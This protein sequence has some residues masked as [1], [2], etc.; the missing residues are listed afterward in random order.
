MPVYFGYPTNL[1]NL[2]KIMNYTIKNPNKHLTEHNDTFEYVTNILKNKNVDLRLFN[3]DKGQIIL[4]YE[5]EEINDVWNNI[6]NVDEVVILLMQLKNKFECETQI[7]GI[8]LN[9]NVEIERME[10]YPITIKNFKPCV[11]CWH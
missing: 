6:M 7:I 4:G 8:N 10:N 9:Y 5:I 3:T 1:V 2:Q 11:L